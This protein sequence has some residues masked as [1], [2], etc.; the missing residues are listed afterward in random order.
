MLRRVALVRTY[1]S[2]ELSASI[3]RVT[4]IGEVGSTLAF[5]CNRVLVTANVPSSPIPVTLMMEEILLWETSVLTRVTRRDIPEDGILH[6]ILRFTINH[7]R[8]MVYNIKPPCA[9][10]YIY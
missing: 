4:E 10:H 8:N 5:T 3:I 1:A 9:F 7:A 2:E 6:G